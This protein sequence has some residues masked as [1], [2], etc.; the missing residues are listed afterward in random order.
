MNT[1][2]LNDV[3]TQMVSD[4]IAD[5]ARDYPD[6]VYNMEIN[7]R[8]LPVV[9]TSVAIMDDEILVV[10]EVRP[11]HYRL[12]GWVKEEEPE[13]EEFDEVFNIENKL[14]TRLLLHNVCRHDANTWL[15]HFQN[16]YPANKPDPNGEGNYPDFGFHIVRV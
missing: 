8:Q 6:L 9:Y 1:K 5:L 16:T 12:S 3:R 14:G 13:P 10:T 11:G 15:K 2:T 4:L 7:P